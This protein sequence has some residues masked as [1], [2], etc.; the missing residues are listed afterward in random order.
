MRR[1]R[2]NAAG[3]DEETRMAAPLTAA[4]VKAR[5]IFS[6]YRKTALTSISDAVFPPG[7]VFSTPEGLL[8]ED[9]PVRAA[10]DVQGGVYPIRES[11]FRASYAA[12]AQSAE[13]EEPVRVI[14]IWDQVTGNL[15]DEIS[16]DDGQVFTLLDSDGSPHRAV[17]S[18]ARRAAP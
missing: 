1:Q 5:S 3:T 13:T 16:L 11:V 9:E 14:Q 2:Q 17:V 6:L 8:A 15:L 12:A 4:T 18:P 7:T 10:M